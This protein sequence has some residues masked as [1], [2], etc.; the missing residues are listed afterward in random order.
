VLPRMDGVRGLASRALLSA[1]DGG[2][3]LWFHGQPSVPN[4]PTARLYISRPVW[5][6]TE[7]TSW[8]VIRTPFAQSSNADR[9]RARGFAH[10][11]EREG[12]D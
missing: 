12:S 2:V 8:N 11:R 1:I 9:F 5:Y 6:V 10:G 3:V 4:H 7:T